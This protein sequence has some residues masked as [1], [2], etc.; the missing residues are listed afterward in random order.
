VV[1]PIGMIGLGLMGSALAERLLGVLESA[2]V[3]GCGDL[4]NSSIINVLVAPGR[5][6]GAT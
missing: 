2:E 1:T 5:D 4:D 3:A 6:R